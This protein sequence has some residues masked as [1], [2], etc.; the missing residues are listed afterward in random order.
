LDDLLTLLRVTDG[1]RVMLALLY[2]ITRDTTVRDDQGRMALPSGLHARLEARVS[3]PTVSR[4]LAELVR[5]GLLDR[6]GGRQGAVYLL[7]RA[8]RLVERLMRTPSIRAALRPGR[9]SRMQ[10]WVECV[11]RRTVVRSAVGESKA[12]YA[13]EVSKRAARP[14][15]A[16]QAKASG[17]VSPAEWGERFRGCVE[18]GFSSVWQPDITK[19]DL[20]LFAKFA[21]ELPDEE[22]DRIMRW[23][24]TSEGWNALRRACK[25]LVA[26]QPTVAIFYGFRAPIIELA[27][28]GATAGPKRSGGAVSRA[29]DDA[30]D[31]STI[32]F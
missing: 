22:L 10:A 31:L 25:T 20:T 32:S 29:E 2:R 13:A 4:R 18:R 28:A 16:K 27:S 24:C 30:R 8:D 14:K 6:E 3:Q 1:A 23:V 26:P 15:R 9:S 19:K 17:R 7:Y 12:A 5:H 11:A 21:R